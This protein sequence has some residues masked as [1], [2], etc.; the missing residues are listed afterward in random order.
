M[1]VLLDIL[2]LDESIIR[3]LP[4]EFNFFSAFFQLKCKRIDR[5][6]CIQALVCET[7]GF[8]LSEER[9]VRI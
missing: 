1:I 5:P 7:E 2:R 4:I 3:M 9:D 6:S 8:A